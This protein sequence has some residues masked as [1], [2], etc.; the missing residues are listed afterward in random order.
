VLSSY[1]GE[2]LLLAFRSKMFLHF[3]RLSLAY[4]DLK[5]SSD[6]M[7]RIQHDATGIQYFVISG[8]IPMLQSL[9]MLVGAIA[10]IAAINWQLALIALAVCPILVFL[11]H[12]SG[13]RIRD[14]WTRVKEKESSALAIIQEA[15]S[16]LRVVKAFGAEQY[17]GRRFTTRSGEVVRGHTEV[18]FL[19]AGVNLLVGLTIAGGTAAV[20]IIGVLEVQ[21]GTI[22]LGELLIVIAYMTMLFQPLE[23][24]TN[25][26]T[27][28]QSS[29]VSAERAFSLL[30]H[31]PEV[32]DRKSAAPLT[33]AKG[34][35]EFRDVSLTYDSRNPSLTGVSLKVAAG[36]RVGI[37]GP[38]GSGKTS[39]INLMT[40]FYDPTGGQILLD[41]FDI[42]DYRVSDLRAQ[43]AIVL[44][45]PILFSASI[46]E[47][48][49]YARPNSTEEEIIEAAKAANAH[50][51]ISRLPDGYSTQVGERGA[52]LSGGERQ[53][54]SLARAFL[55]N[56][57]ILILDEPTSSVD[58]GTEE[59]IISALENLMRGRTTFMIA[60]R[61]GTLR[62][63]DTLL[64]LHQGKLVE[65]SSKPGGIGL[66]TFDAVAE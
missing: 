38:T 60:H 53:R 50:D 11:T 31:S 9:T 40:R 28:L 3:Q 5:G 15:L 25:R 10:V 26:V 35:I 13:T 33:R 14:R 30:D 62:T 7:Y 45:E 20:L 24:L 47:N 61:H 65:F 19:C 29:L 64:R 43:F 58:V 17:E 46:A 56:A 42:R 27:D 52:R 51:F 44:Q 54:I 48:I 57:P 66:D 2:R 8:V 63:C 39:L 12:Y 34:E 37:V 6:S 18:A 16:A 22:T 59:L 55:R 4:H 49:S 36:Q 32:E 1:A 21:A 41:G 23:Q